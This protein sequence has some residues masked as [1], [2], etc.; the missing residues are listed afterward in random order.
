MPP[1]SAVAEPRST[2]DPKPDTRLLVVVLLIASALRVPLAFWPNFHHPD[3]IFQYLEPAWR[4]LG[5]DGIISW[6]WRHGVRSWL[7]PTM[8]SAPV[9]IGD[10]IAPGGPGAFI[11]PRILAA[12]AS[13]SIVV[14]AWTFGARVSPRHA[15]L[16]GFVTA[17]WFEL[18]YFAPHTLSE[19][20]AAAIFLPAALLLTRDPPSQRTLLAAG[21]LLALAFLLRIQFAPAIVVLILWA[22]W[23]NPARLTPVM[24]GGIAVLSLGGLFDAAHEA[25]PFGW[26]LANVDQNLVKGRAAGFGVSPADA[27]PFWIWSA[28]S[29]AAVPLGFAIYRGYRHAPVLFWIA[30]INIAAQTPI[31]HKE[32]RFIFLSVALFVILAALGSA[33]WTEP[34]RDAGH[35]W[36]RLLLATG[37]ISVSV[38]LAVSG[39]MPELWMRGVGAANLAATLKSDSEMCGLALYDVPFFLLPGRDRLAGNASLFAL[40]ST[41]PLA[42]GRLDQAT[43]AA[44]ASFNR[45]LAE[46]TAERNLPDGFARKSCDTV[47]GRPICIFVRDGS[48]R[49]G[50]VS[51]FTLNEVLKRVDL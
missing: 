49:S 30:V 19:P 11:A 37:W 43:L 48:C 50:E 5:H 47:G 7:L 41:D 4:M 14:S 28:W 32:Y 44:S 51:A 12:L 42:R 24:L 25:V 9:A 3:E 40:Y 31:A 35:R 36:P 18:V 20:V 1:P 27:Y 46:R 6:E 17:I 22:S 29:V 13:L 26:I 39:R 2:E 10:W 16:A 15:V 34:R 21:A 8:L 38:V 45:I 23:R 33:D